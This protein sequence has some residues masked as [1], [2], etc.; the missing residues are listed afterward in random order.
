MFSNEE[1]IR[2]AGFTS[3]K[4]AQTK[5]AQFMAKEDTVTLQ[6]RQKDMLE[7][8]SSAIRNGDMDKMSGYI[9]QYIEM[10]G[11]PK[12]AINNTRFRQMLVTWNT[13][14]QSQKALG[15]K[16]YAGIQ[17]YLR[18]KD[19]LNEVRSQYGSNSNQK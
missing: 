2:S 1:D 19:M 10:S 16:N 18:T 8:M 14:F 6:N 15:A 3:T 13:D 4:E 5:E 12:Q 7:N 17:D 11:D 9:K